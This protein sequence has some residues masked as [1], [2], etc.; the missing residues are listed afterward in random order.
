MV[1]AVIGECLGST[2]MIR[3][4]QLH[5]RVWDALWPL[6]GR[7]IREFYNFGMETLLQLD[8]DGT[9]RFFD[10]FFELD[11]HYWHG[12]LS[13][14]LS[15]GELLTSGFA[16]F[17]LSSNR[18]KLDMLMKCPVPMARMMGNMAVEAA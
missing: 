14:R 6:E 8:L 4:V 11:P 12:F 18:S 9:R 13:S 3:G 16:L 10:A 15:L 1:A 17:R 2:R 5:R 7:R